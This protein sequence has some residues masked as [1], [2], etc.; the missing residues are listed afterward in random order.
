M[1]ARLCFQNSHAPFNSANGSPSVFGTRSHARA[2]THRHLCACANAA[3][4]AA[5][6]SSHRNGALLHPFPQA[7]DNQNPEAHLLLKQCAN[8][9]HVPFEWT[10]T[11]CA[12]PAFHAECFCKVLRGRRLLVIG[13]SMALDLATALYGL[14]VARL[15]IPLRFPLGAVRARDVKAIEWPICGPSATPS[16]Q[17]S[18]AYHFVE[19]LQVCFAEALQPHA[20][21]GVPSAQAVVLTL[22]SHFFVSMG[23]DERG[24]GVL[25]GGR[26]GHCGCG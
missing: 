10:T 6:D 19:K 20:P 23:G 9:S 8:Q 14:T 18:I 26:E 1:K 22:S 5:E 13:D 4:E 15:H 3:L 24:R 17:S 16:L 21:C 25:E 11:A 7:W 2:R 12:L